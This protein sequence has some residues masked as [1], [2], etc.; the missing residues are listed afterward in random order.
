MKKQIFLSLLILNSTFIH[1]MQNYVPSFVL[2]LFSLNNQ[3]PRQESELVSNLHANKNNFETQ[4]A[5]S[6][7]I[8]IEDAAIPTQPTQQI[9]RVIPLSN[10]CSINIAPTKFLQYCYDQGLYKNDLFL[11]MKIN[12]LDIFEHP[13][14]LQKCQNARIDDYSALSTAMLAPNV[15]F[16]NRRKFIQ[17][18]L[19]KRN[20]KPTPKDI[21]LAQLIFYDEIIKE[22]QSKSLSLKAKKSKTKLMYVLHPYFLPTLPQELKRFIAYFIIE[23]LKKEENCWL[24]PGF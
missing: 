5:R 8:T 15:F 21:Q 14:F 16:K 22:T 2:K 23:M 17:E 7:N 13:H 20:F 24:L 3:A 6:H 12:E 1:T 4:F 19:I 10:A 11:H 18:E 9:Q